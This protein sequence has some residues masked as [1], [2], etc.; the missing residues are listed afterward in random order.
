MDDPKLV[1]LANA[2]GQRSTRV[3][4]PCARPG[5]A[6][7]LLFQTAPFDILHLQEDETV[8]VADVIDL[9][10]VGVPQPGDRL[11]LGLEA[12]CSRLTGVVAGQN[13]LEGAETI[14]ADLTG[15]I[16]DSHAAAAEFVQNLVAGY[17]G[18]RPPRPG[19]SDAVGQG[20]HGGVAPAVA[21]TIPPP[22]LLATRGPLG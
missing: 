18:Y 22:R 6:V 16:D 1:R 9:G 5:G 7:E 14:Q 11:G 15:Q 19:R 17:G 2:P 4:Q 3:P 20:R 13:H 8:M 21:G 12:Q 10:D